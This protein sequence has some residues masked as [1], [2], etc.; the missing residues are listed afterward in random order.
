MIASQI[1]DI[2]AFTHNGNN[3]V[4]PNLLYNTVFTSHEALVLDYE[5]TFPEWWNIINEK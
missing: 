5:N 1:Q 3:S 2:L 4:F